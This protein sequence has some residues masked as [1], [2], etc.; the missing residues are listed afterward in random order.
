MAFPARP[1][2]YFEQFVQPFR[3]RPRGRGSARSSV[4]FL[5]VLD[6]NRLTR[7]ALFLRMI[8]RRQRR[9][10][11]NYFLKMRKD[12]LVGAH[13]SI[14]RGNHKAIEKGTDL[15]S[16]GEQNFVLYNMKLRMA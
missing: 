6:Q 4:A 14:A 3:T 15:G 11:R 12:F 7:E 10:D 5:S 1:A 2:K 9:Q 16:E 8:V 13:L